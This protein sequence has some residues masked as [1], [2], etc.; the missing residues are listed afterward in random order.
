MVGSKCFLK[1]LKCRKKYENCT[2][3]LNFMESIITIWIWFLKKLWFTIKLKKKKIVII[4]Q[5]LS[6]YQKLENIILFKYLF[7]TII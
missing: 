7:C 5:S 4:L 2:N 3:S 6:K 1:L